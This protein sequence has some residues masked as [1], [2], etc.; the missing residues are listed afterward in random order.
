VKIIVC[1]KQVPDAT[2]VKI[3]PQTNTLIRDGVRSII[4]PFD[5][6]AIEEAMRIK[7]SY[8]ATTTAV[9]M[10]PPQA[11]YAL[12]EAMAMGID[13][14]FLISHRDFAGSDTLATSHVLAKAIEHI[15][16]ADLIICGKQASDGDTAQV[17]PGIAVRLGLPQI[18]FVRSVKEIVASFITAVRMTDDGFDVVKAPLPCLITVVKEIGEPRFATFLGKVRAKR[19]KIEA[20]GPKGIG[21]DAGLIGLDG[22]PTCVE[23]IFPPRAKAG[24]KPIEGSEKNIKAVADEIKRHL[25]NG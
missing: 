4:N 15:G 9:T 13:D 17:G 23:K 19:K 16:G 18:T 7:E 14:A 11:R 21:C 22:S 25:R 12:E 10:G 6:Y 3:N 24:V 1:I 2:D 5:M 20:L 8:S